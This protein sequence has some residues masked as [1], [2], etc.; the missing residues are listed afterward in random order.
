M[1][2]LEDKRNPFVM[3]RISVSKRYYKKEW[4]VLTKYLEIQMTRHDVH[5]DVHKYESLI[6]MYN[7]VALGTS[8]YIGL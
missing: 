7:N 6:K 8:G 4:I 5:V 3:A 1:E 2:E